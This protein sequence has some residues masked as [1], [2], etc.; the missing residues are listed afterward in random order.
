LGISK[1]LNPSIP[2]CAAKRKEV[3]RENKVMEGLAYSLTKK[4]V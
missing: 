2:Q 4:E 1:F 3:K